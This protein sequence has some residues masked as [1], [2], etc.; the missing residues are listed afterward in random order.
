MAEGS[1]ICR[2]TSKNRPMLPMSKLHVAGLSRWGPWAG[3]LTR[4]VGQPPIG[5]NQPWPSS[6]GLS[7]GPTCHWHEEWLLLCQ[8][9]ALVGPLI[10][11]MACVAL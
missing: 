3:Q 4:V 6:V 11:V 10:H 8:F 5:P 1:S 7:S 9:L 2:C